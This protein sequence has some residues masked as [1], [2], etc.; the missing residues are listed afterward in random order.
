MNKVEGPAAKAR[1]GNSG[2]NTRLLKIIRR[3]HMFT[4]L[5]MLPWVLMYGLSALVFNHNSWFFS[6]A[7]QNQAS[8]QS[9]ETRSLPESFWS[10]AGGGR[11]LWMAWRRGCCC[12]GSADLPLS[13]QCS[14]AECLKAVS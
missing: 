7:K 11:R 14:T 5:F 10:S 4:G 12:G 2:P 8:A 3:T 9:R 6:N 13:I 1:T